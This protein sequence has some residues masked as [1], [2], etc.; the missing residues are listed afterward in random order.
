[1]KKAFFETHP[2]LRKGF[3]VA[4]GVAV[5]AAAVLMFGP[6]KVSGWIDKGFDAALGVFLP[7]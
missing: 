2:H 1:M 3:Y 6:D 5:V 4:L 7:K